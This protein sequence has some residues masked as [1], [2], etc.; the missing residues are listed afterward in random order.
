MRATSSTMVACVSSP[1]HT[2]PASAPWE[3]RK[4]ANSAA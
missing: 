4:V 2:S 3:S 1:N